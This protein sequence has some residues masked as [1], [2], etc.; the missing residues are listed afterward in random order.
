M[1]VDVE[2]RKVVVRGDFGM[3]VKGSGAGAGEGVLNDIL[4]V[5]G[6]DERGGKVVEC[7]EF[8]D[9]VAAGEIK[10]RMEGVKR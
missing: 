10:K 9:P 4:F 7:M 2:K 8:V 3:V 6:M 5:M 1:V